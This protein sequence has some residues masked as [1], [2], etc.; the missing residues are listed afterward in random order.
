MNSL[1]HRPTDPNRFTFDAS[2]AAVFDDMAERSLPGYGNAY[3]AIGH[4]AGRMNLPRYTQVWDMGTSTGA[5]MLA[6]K[7]GVGLNPYLDF[8]GVD[9]SEPMLDKAH[10]KCPFATVV[11]HDLTTGMPEQMVPGKVSVIVFGWVLQ[12]IEGHEQRVRILTE[13]YNALMPGGFIAVME[14]YDLPHPVM[15]AVMQ[16]SYIDMRRANGYSL[17]EIE[18]KTKALK[19]SMW[20]NDP[21]FCTEVLTGLGAN[22]HILYRELNFGG[23]VAFKPEV[24]DELRNTIPTQETDA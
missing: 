16:D 3:R 6:I 21:D 24:T 8:Y 11:K 17:N 23:I 9:I 1:K 15:N 12:F 10:S 22:V 19:G 13:A 5:G 18:A 20:P 2:V 7:E 4:L 14:K